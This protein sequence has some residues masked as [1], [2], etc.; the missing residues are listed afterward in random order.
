MDSVSTVVW[1]C[2]TPNALTLYLARLA[3]TGQRIWFVQLNVRSGV[4]LLRAQH[5]LS[6]TLI[7]G[8]KSA[9][10]L[11]PGLGVLER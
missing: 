2:S 3:V 6:P 10:S 7:F 5:L 9:S 4:A 11:S 1:N 8:L